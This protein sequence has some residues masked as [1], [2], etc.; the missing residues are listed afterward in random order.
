MPTLVS[1]VN[2]TRD[3]EEE[4]GEVNEGKTSEPHSE[5]VKREDRTDKTEGKLE[6]GKPETEKP[7][8]KEDG[9]N[10]QGK[11]KRVKQ[12]EIKQKNGNKPNQVRARANRKES[13]G[14]SPIRESSN[15]RVNDSMETL[16]V[17]HETVTTRSSRALV[18]ATRGVLKS[19]MDLMSFLTGTGIGSAGSSSRD[20]NPETGKYLAKYAENNKTLA[21]MAMN[22][23][24]DLPPETIQEIEEALSRVN[25]AQKPATEDAQMTPEE[26]RR[27]DER[28]LV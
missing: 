1:V 26:R 7:K 10:I 27:E 5:G 13:N 8:A 14:R 20:Y 19:G 24:S 16:D 28:V 15:Q 11:T 22:S 21:D 23:N 25:D 9:K 3:R 12:T 4:R 18:G 17:G 2:N 6:D